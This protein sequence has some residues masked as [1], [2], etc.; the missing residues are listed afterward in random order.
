MNK[1]QGLVT[2]L[3]GVMSTFAVGVNLKAPTPPDNTENSKYSD[4]LVLDREGNI[5]LNLQN[6]RVKENIE[7]QIR[8]ASKISVEKASS[9]NK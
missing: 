8:I 9:D 4:V 3:A 7:E 2:S 5:T 1:I 6:K